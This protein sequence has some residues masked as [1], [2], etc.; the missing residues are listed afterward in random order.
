MPKIASLDR[1][2][3]QQPAM[4]CA[5]SVC[6]SRNRINAKYNVDHIVEWLESAFATR[7]IV[8][9]VLVAEILV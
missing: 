7:F 1:V 8:F 4:I 9:H 5:G 2:L 6:A 3:S